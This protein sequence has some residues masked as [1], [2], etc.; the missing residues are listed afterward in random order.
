MSIEDLQNSERTKYT[1]IAA[2]TQ[3]I[4]FLNFL[5]AKKKNLISTVL[6]RFF[7]KKREKKVMVLVR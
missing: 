6:S 3:I 5:T 2:Q 1:K 4:L 7:F